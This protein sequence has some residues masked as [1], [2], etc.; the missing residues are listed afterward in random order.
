MDFDEVFMVQYGHYP[1]RVLVN[2][3]SKIAANM[4]AMYTNVADKKLDPCILTQFF[5]YNICTT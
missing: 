3:F 4:A 2:F 5:V 1:G